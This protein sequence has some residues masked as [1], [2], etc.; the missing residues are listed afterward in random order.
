MFVSFQ[1]DLNILN[2]PGQKYIPR[3]DLLN[4]EWNQRLKFLGFQEGVYK[5]PEYYQGNE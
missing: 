5:I 4:T 3:V 2:F 1:V